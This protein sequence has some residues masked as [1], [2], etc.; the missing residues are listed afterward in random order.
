MSKGY[1][2]IIVG[3]G[4]AG[5]VRNRSALNI[6]KIFCESVILRL[7]FLAHSV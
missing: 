4:S 7:Q 3:A 2:Y 1:D 6:V 5:A